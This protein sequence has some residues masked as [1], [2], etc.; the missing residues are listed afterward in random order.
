M[1][2]GL[3]DEDLDGIAQM[4][5]PRL[6]AAAAAEYPDARHRG[7]WIQGCDRTGYARGLCQPHHLKVRAWKEQR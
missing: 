2:S 6:D 5:I 4:L 1:P 7:C 3:T